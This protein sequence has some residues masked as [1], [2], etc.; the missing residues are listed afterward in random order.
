MKLRQNAIIVKAC[1]DRLGI[2][3]I[4]AEG[5]EESTIK[6]KPVKEKRVRLRLAL[7]TAMIVTAGIAATGLF[8]LTDRLARDHL[9]PL[10]PHLTEAS[11]SLTSSTGEVMTND[12][13]IGQAQVM[14]FG[15]TH[16]PEICPTTIYRLSSTI[17]TLGLSDQVG[18]VFVTV[19]P[20]RDDVEALSDYIGNFSDNV[21]ALTGTDQDVKT[22]AD[23]YRVVIQRVDLA[24]GD[25]TVDH[26]A[27][28]FMFDPEG[29][30]S[31]VIAWGESDQMIEGK[32]LRLVK[33][34]S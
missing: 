12:D 29:A 18:I 33:A 17:E 10:F 13:L 15:F 8:L 31:G 2:A 14:F 22:L 26:T 34:G 28:V 16:C 21:T 30:F 19:D 7:I 9:E 23:H 3:L 25:Y 32:I 20:A 4:R 27:S 11:F 6:T 24:D 5:Y 1:S